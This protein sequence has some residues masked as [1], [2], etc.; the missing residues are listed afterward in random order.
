MAL[1][2]NVA[3]KIIDVVAADAECWRAIDPNPNKYDPLRAV[4]QKVAEFAQISGGLR[5]AAMLA[6]GKGQG[7][8]VFDRKICLGIALVTQKA[9]LKA[10][11]ARQLPEVLSCA[12]LHRVHWGIHHQAT[13]VRM[14]DDTEYVFDW[15][16]TLNVRNPSISKAPNWLKGEKGVLFWWFLGFDR[17]D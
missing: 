5:N 1:S 14:A 8:E 2:R 17:A 6:A 11:T 15:H 9:I 12:G 13:W 4:G 16:A 7:D 10:V 3:Q